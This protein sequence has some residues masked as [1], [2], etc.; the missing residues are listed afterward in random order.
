MLGFASAKE[1]TVSSLR[2]AYERNAGVTLVPSSFYDRFTDNLVELLRRLADALLEAAVGSMEQL[3]GAFSGFR[4]VMITDA[5]VI[6]LRE[7]LEQEFPACWTNHTK[8]AAKLHAV[9]SVT[10]LSAQTVS[11]TGERTNDRC[12]LRIGPWVSERLLLF[13]LGYF[14]YRLFDRIRRNS[15]FFISRMKK[16]SNP[17][18]VSTNRR[19]RGRSVPL[20][21]EH[22]QDV[23]HRL[24][25]QELDVNVEVSFK[26]R[27]Y[28]GCQKQATTT[29][30]VVAVRNAETGEYHVYVTNVPPGRL[31]AADVALAYRARWMVELLF[32][33]WKGELR[34]DEVPSRKKEVVEALIYAAI[35][36]MLLTQRL[37]AFLRAKAG[38]HARRVTL[39]RVAAAVRQF[40]SDL[41]GLVTGLGTNM[42]SGRLQRLLLHEAVDPHLRRPSVLELAS[43]IAPEA[44]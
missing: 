38:E 7:L 18:I 33:T 42:P 6:R 34:L 5:S 9:M 24:H 23:L 35:L 10:G 2:R 36:T 12:A 44:L 32:K 19:W 43:G 29:F 1:R 37:F 27:A 41:L 26:R 11:I 21:G 8:A 13:D 4:D 14:G 16:N 31:S 22:L 17:M 39:G 25:R 15:G 30:R 20:V 3:A 40:A 28:R